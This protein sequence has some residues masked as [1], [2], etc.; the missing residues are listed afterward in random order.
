[1]KGCLYPQPEQK[2]SLTKNPYQII[3]SAHATL[4]RRRRRR[5]AGKFA[6]SRRQKQPGRRRREAGSFE[7]Q[8]WPIDEN[9]L[10][11]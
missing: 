5:Q 9:E 1:M 7:Y 10:G 11:R 3:F 8:D 2:E 6:R 4:T